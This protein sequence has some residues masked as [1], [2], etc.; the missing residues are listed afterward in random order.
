MG[1]LA[2]CQGRWVRLLARHR[3]VESAERAA[4][5]NLCLAAARAR[6]ESVLPR[7]HDIAGTGAVQKVLLENSK[8]ISE[9]FSSEWLSFDDI[10]ERSVHR[11]VESAR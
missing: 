4:R 2:R 8:R 11:R 5:G 9:A 1:V 7:G 10:L 3:P 6:Y